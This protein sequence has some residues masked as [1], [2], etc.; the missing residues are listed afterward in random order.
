MSRLAEGAAGSGEYEAEEK[1]FEDDR[2]DAE[3]GGTCKKKPW[4]VKERKA[5]PQTTT[6]FELDVTIQYMLKR[7]DGTARIRARSITKFST[8]NATVR[9]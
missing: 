2:C 8:A 7:R 6:D 4:K 5:Y 3:I 1:R 9:A